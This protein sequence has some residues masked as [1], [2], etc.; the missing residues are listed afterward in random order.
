MCTLAELTLGTKTI[1]DP[2]AVWFTD[3]S[4]CKCDCVWKAGFAIGDLHKE[5]L[6]FGNLGT[7][8]CTGLPSLA[9]PRDPKTPR[10]STRP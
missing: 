5:L 9:L 8:D 6:P 1:E 2:D 4:S 7:H 10:D 3:G